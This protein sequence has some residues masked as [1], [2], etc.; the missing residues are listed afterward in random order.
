MVYF[1]LLHLTVTIQI[2][3]MKGSNN[4]GKSRK[5]NAR[6]R[7]KGGG[8]KGM[9]F[10]L[11]KD[12]NA[13]MRNKFE[14]GRFVE[15]M[16]SFSSKAE[17]LTHLDDNRYY[18]PTRL[19][20][21]LAFI[22][23]VNSINEI[24]VPMILCIVDNEISRPLYK[25]ARIR[26]IASIHNVPGLMSFL[27]ESDIV[28]MLPPNSADIICS[29]L[30]L[31]VMTLVEARSCNNI[32]CLAKA[33]KRNGA[34]GAQ[35]VCDLL[36]IS[37]EK[38]SVATE[39]ESSDVACWVSDLRPPGGRHDND[40]KNYRDIQIVPTQEE[41]NSQSLP[42]LPLASQDNA[43][44]ESREMRMLDS[45]FRLLRE[46]AV[47]SMR[48]NLEEGKRVWTNARIL[49]L[50]NG[51]E[52]AGKEKK[53]QRIQ[54]LSFM[55]QLSSSY[56]GKKMNWERSRALPLE[57]VIAFCD[58]V[59]KKVQRMGTITT[60][61]YKE[62]DKWLNDPLGPIIGVSF[63]NEDDVL[64]SLQEALENMKI[65]AVRSDSPMEKWQNVEGLFLS[66]T[67]IEAS[68]SFFSYKP[69]LSALQELSSIPLA[70]ELA[71]L[72]P[73]TDRP[74]YLPAQMLMP[75]TPS[76][77][78]FCCELDGWSNQKI[79]DNTSL[80]ESQADA[81]R[82]ALN[83]KVALIQGPPGKKHMQQPA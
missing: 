42:W 64:V 22:E 67:L 1:T 45:N 30:E 21:A 74:D 25:K 68:G 20:E 56:A 75:K 43:F 66:Y 23:D 72:N 16:Q 5:Y 73:S 8:A 53:K 19:Q 60:R 12:E 9:F 55:V 83:S 49:G 78:G 2:D 33:L 76:F 52:N 79:I 36:L 4:W 54:P 58:P 24:L 81:L 61:L 15:G 59:D 48:S 65:L 27:S 7:Q 14:A 46:D 31:I 17:M 80:D 82:C 40:H 26:V 35:K 70:Q 57:G 10:K 71:Y 32:H 6:T 63:H 41:I 34:R 44:I 29:L 51:Y 11:L 3:N 13:Q 28:E 77:K 47:S 69:V 50:N 37:P 62:K 39:H 18:G 38:S